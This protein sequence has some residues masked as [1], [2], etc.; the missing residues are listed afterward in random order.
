MYNRL[1]LCSVDRFWF[2]LFRRRVGFL[3]EML[4]ISVLNGDRLSLYNA[5][6]P[7]SSSV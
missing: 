1:S 5:F 2:L 7:S 6:R 3:L 4:L